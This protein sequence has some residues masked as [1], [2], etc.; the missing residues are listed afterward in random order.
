MPPVWLCCI[1]YSPLGC[2]SDS[3]TT[4]ALQGYA[5][6]TST[7]TPANCEST[8]LNQGFTYA[9]VEY[10][11]ECYCGNSIVVSSGGGSVA[12]SSDC[13]MACSGDSTQ[14]CGAGNR[15]FIYQRSGSPATAS[16]TSTTSAATSTASSAW[17]S[18]G[19]YADS[20][21]RVLSG[22]NTSSSSL[23]T[24][25]CQSYCKGQGYSYA[26]TE[27]S[28]QCFCANSLAS[29]AS[30]SSNCNM[31]CG[32]NSA[33]T[34]GGNY[35]INIYQL[36]ASSTTTTT[37]TTSAVSTTSAAPTT[38]A[39]TG[40]T[41]TNMGCYQDTS[42]RVL[43][44]YSTTSSS[45]TPASCEATC[46]GKGYTYAGTE[47]G[48]ECW[49][50]SS[51]ASGAQS[52]ASSNCNV[53]CAG[54]SAQTC[55]GTWAINIYSYGGGTG[56][57]TTATSTTAPTTTA[58]ATA[59]PTP[60]KVV[61]AHHMV[62]NTYD[63]TQATWSSDI[64]MALAGGIDGFALNVG[65]VDWELS[66]V[67]DAYAAASGTSFK[68][69]VSL[70]MTALPCA[71]ASDANL[72]RSYLNNFASHPNQLYY[73][74]RQVISTFSGSDCT[75]GQGSLNAGW[76]YA[77]KTG[78]SAQN[79][80]IPS[81]FSDVSTFAGNS[82]QDGDFN[83]N[84]GWPMGSTDIDWSSDQTHLNANSGRLYIAAVTPAFFTHY[85]PNSYN[86]NWIYRSDDNLYNARWD[87][88]YQHRS[89]IDIVE[90]ISW[91]DY[92]ESHYVGP[93]GP[94]QPNSQAWV[95]G[96]DHTPWTTMTKYYADAWRTGVY[97]TITKNKIYLSSR[98]HPKG[99]SA[100]S[101]SVGI[102]NNWQWTDDNIYCVVFSTGSYTLKLSIGSSSG[103]F[104]I[105]QG[106]NSV[107]LAMAIG[108]ASASLVDGSGNTVLS[109]NNAFTVVSNPTT[110]NFNYYIATTS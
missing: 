70:D 52:I 76:N 94:D 102:P 96:F 80:F 63:Y 4:R 74:G 69:F 11:Q 17:K 73:K 13:N 30:T 104:A 45:N 14:T 105:T 83:W 103:S 21:T 110:Y 33:E 65:S 37:T 107:K 27:Y 18:L 20:S 90:I 15:M 51:I 89:Q 7:N 62:G 91:N 60:S 1:L 92:G 75:F 82:F 67:T 59:A 35:A 48:Q 95:N 43:G 72:V 47:Y 54:N 46:L 23:T 106:V 42:S 77:V 29:G 31:A 10:G 34:C 64:A 26:G 81:F 87:M 53:A 97:P 16:T 44:S 100:S 5:A 8:C 55:G 22:P 79:Y 84:G 39:S 68:L 101:D 86:K 66:R 78:V 61:V 32:G 109:L 93:I 88:L 41:W 19:C 40:A 9:G 108:S 56:S 38:T 99:A 12:S 24:E 28:V 50:A 85:G 3:T 58:T 98:P 71:G 2:Y 57:T 25:T 49:C 36:T 6:T